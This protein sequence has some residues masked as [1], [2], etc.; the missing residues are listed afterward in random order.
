[1]RREAASLIANIPGCTCEVSDGTLQL[2]YQMNAAEAFGEA[3]A[4]ATVAMALG[5]AFGRQFM[6]SI[7]LGDGELP[8]NPF[9][10][11][12]VVYSESIASRVAATIDSV[13]IPQETEENYVEFKDANGKNFVSLMGMLNT[14]IF[15]TGLVLS[16]LTFLGENAPAQGTKAATFVTTPLDYNGF[17][18]KQGKPTKVDIQILGA[19]VIDTPVALDYQRGLIYDIL[20]GEDTTMSMTFTGMEKID[21]NLF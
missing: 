16:N 1:M 5:S 15:K 4:P 9:Y 20:V 17:E 7:R 19:T 14:L 21:F 2:N 12:A 11:Q 18:A 10:Q 6:S 8:Q 13:G 3:V